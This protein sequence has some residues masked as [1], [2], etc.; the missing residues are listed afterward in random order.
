MG[1][2]THGLTEI[3][4]SFYL[5]LC[6]GGSE[7]TEVILKRDPQLPEAFSCGISG[8]MDI[9]TVKLVNYLKGGTGNIFS[10]SFFK[11]LVPWMSFNLGK[12]EFC[13]IRVHA[14]NFLPGWGS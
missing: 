14:L 4:K 3:L 10:V 5:P 2:H 11:Y 13:V 1:I 7:S 6:F 9:Y 8:N 12:L